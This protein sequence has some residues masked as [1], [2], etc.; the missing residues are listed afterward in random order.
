MDRTFGRA[1]PESNY[2][3]LCVR[4]REVGA[5]LA[6][7][8]IVRWFMDRSTRLPADCNLIDGR[9]ERIHYPPSESKEEIDRD[10]RIPLLRRWKTAG[11]SISRWGLFCADA[12]EDARGSRGSRAEHRVTWDPRAERGTVGRE[13]LIAVT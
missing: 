5:K 11:V 12:G 8:F 10:G 7:A 13:I 2:R 9:V 6:F 4:P 3:C 1:K